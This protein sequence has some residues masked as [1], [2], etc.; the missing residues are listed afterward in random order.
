M[1]RNTHHA[2]CDLGHLVG[3]VDLGIS[4]IGAQPVNRPSFDLARRKDQV[5]GAVLNLG[6]ADTTMRVAKSGNGKIWIR[7]VGKNESAREG[8]PPGAILR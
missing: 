2:S 1:L 3:A 7:D 4:D 5:H 6:S 8:Y